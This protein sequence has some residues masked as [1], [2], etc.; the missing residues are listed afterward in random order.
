MALSTWLP[1]EQGFVGS[2]F[3]AVA[4]MVNFEDFIDIVMMAASYYNET[5]I[6]SCHS[7][8]YNLQRYTWNGFEA[9]IGDICQI[10]ATIAGY[11][12]LFRESWPRELLASDEVESWNN[13]R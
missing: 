5:N 8:L 12:N 1:W 2:Q 4:A 11:R 6:Q 7:C 13:S 3:E 9:L 10:K